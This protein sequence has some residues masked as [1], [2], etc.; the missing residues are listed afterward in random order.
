MLISNIKNLNTHSK[1]IYITLLFIFILLVGFNYTK[2]VTKKVD[3]N[4]EIKNFLVKYENLKAENK[5]FTVNTYGITKADKFITIKS[6]ISGRVIKI[7]KNKGQKINKGEV[8]ITLADRNYYQILETHENDLLKK[9][10]KLAKLLR[11][12]INK[13]NS[14]FIGAEKEIQIAADKLEKAKLY[15]NLQYIR[16]PIDGYIEN[17]DPEEGDT[18]DKGNILVQII[19]SNPILVETYI[20]EKFIHQVK[21]NDKAKIS[22]QNY[23]DIDGYVKFVAKKADPIT[24]SFKCDIMINNPDII[25]PFGTTA[26]IKIETFKVNAFKIK[27]SYL[28]I[29]DDGN[30]GIKT[31]NADNIVKF[32]KVE[33]LEESADNIWVYGINKNNIKIISLGHGYVSDGEKVSGSE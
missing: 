9:K 32:D 23:P 6:D 18:V 7:H 20:P 22:L 15:S 21:I 12:N 14:I 1:I 30:I 17:I 10:N 5:Y 4:K 31:L 2:N 25:L 13:S 26:N 19:Q 11:N 29:S 33:I 24:R 27:T 8:I 3:D 28:T 16:S